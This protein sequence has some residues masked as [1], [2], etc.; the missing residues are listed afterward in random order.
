MV[1]R[2]PDGAEFELASEAY[3]DGTEI[4]IRGTSYNAAGNL[5]IFIDSLRGSYSIKSEKT[6]NTYRF[7]F[8]DRDEENEIEIEER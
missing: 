2:F 8:A 5:R 4:Y 6:G 3:C 7:I 1:I